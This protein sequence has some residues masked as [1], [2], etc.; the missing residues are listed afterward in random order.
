MLSLERYRMLDLSRMFPGPFTS[1]V[2]AD[3]GME[4]IRVEEPEPRYGMPRDTLSPLNHTP[5]LEERY[6]AYNAVSRNKKSI[7]LNLVDPGKRPQCQEIFY[8]LA[9]RADVVLDGY[10]PGTLEWMGVDYETVKAYNPRIIYCCLTGFGHTGP[11]ARRPG[12][13]GQFEALG[14]TMRLDGE[15]VP[16]GAGLALGDLSGAL[17]ATTS[18]L[19]AL[20]HREHTG[21]GQFIDVSL[22]AAAMALAVSNAAQLARGDPRPP[23]AARGTNALSLLKCKDGKW[24]STGNAETIFWEAFCKALGR[25][26]WI[27]LRRTQGPETEKMVKEVQKIFLTKSRDEWLEILVKAD[28]C[29][30]PVN[31]IE[32]ALQ[33]PHMRQIG[34]VWEM[35][36]PKMGTI[37]QTGFPVRFS[38]KPVPPGSFGPVLGQHT[39]EILK[40]EGYSQA[41]IAELEQQGVV[42]S[43]ESLLQ[44]SQK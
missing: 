19:A 28:T 5:E 7:A 25:P 41:Q 8:R 43:W 6:A 22:S 26:E 24:L 30:A 18:I 9:Q 11:Y 32:A 14:G 16:V 4:V 39:R 40:E 35:E 23:Q 10:R 3:L 2:L 44:K 36:H 42:E 33:D 13:G 1:H 21:E 38:G 34:M 17:H 15:G 27:P 37:T 31:D 20:L 12:H 29:V